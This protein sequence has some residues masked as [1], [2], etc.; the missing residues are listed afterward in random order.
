MFD[1]TTELQK[2]KTHNIM[3]SGYRRFAAVKTDYLRLGLVFCESREER[4]KLQQC[5]SFK[6]QRSCLE[7]DY[8]T[9]KNILL[10]AIT[11]FSVLFQKTRDVR[12]HFVSNYALFASI[13]K[14]Q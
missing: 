11:I 12:K 6:K 4:K 8:K 14:S 1:R 7:N 9:R 10:K 13:E 5:L 2:R 3:K